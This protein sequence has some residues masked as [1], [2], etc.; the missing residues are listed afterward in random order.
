MCGKA[1]KYRTSDNYVFGSYAEYIE[2]LMHMESYG[3]FDRYPRMMDEAQ[4]ELR[5]Y[6]ARHSV[7]GME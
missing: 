6:D 7:M 1:I 3:F 4:A 5:A 2:H